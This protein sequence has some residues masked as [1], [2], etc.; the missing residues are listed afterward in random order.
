VSEARA[1]IAGGAAAGCGASAS[2]TL[3]VTR[4]ELLKSNAPQTPRCADRSASGDVTERRGSVLQE[5]LLSRSERQFGA[6]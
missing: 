3:I 4:I 1:E 6:G 5:N 2:D